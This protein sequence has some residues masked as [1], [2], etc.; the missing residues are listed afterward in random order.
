MRRS[1]NGIVAMF[2]Q[3]KVSC[4]SQLQKSVALSTIEAEIEGAKQLTW[5]TRLLSELVGLDELSPTLH[6]DNASAVKLVKNPEFHK[7]I[8]HVEVRHFY[9]RERVL[10]GDISIEHIE[11]TKQ[12]TDLFTKTLERNRYETLRKEIRVCSNK[13]F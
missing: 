2:S 1:T 10:N 7:R 6:V 9:V 3:A 13:T 5:L 11:G 4:T 12:L 8:I